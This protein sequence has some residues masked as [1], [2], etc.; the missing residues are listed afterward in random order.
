[1]LKGLKV[2]DRVMTSGGLFGTIVDGGD[3]I[4]K[5]EIAD[6]VRVDVGRGYIAGKL[7]LKES[8]EALPRRPKEPEGQARGR[9]PPA[10]ADSSASC[11]ARSRGA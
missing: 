10:S 6:K 4:V 11:S 3:Q 9:T 5:L 1:M 7:V 8:K 2:G